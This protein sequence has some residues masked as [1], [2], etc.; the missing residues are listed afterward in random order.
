MFTYSIHDYAN[1]LEHTIKHGLTWHAN[2]PLGKEDTC[3][4]EGKKKNQKK[5]HLP[6]IRMLQEQK[7]PISEQTALWPVSA[8]RHIQSIPTTATNH[9]YLD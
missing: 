4:H 3:L 7:I 2:Y 8:M 9:Y 5:P 6:G 1:W